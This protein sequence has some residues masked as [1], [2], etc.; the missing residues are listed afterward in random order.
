M[1]KRGSKVS[2]TA[3]QT[4]DLH[5]RAGEVVAVARVSPADSGQA[6]FHWHLGSDGSVRRTSRENGTQRTLR[7]HR[8]ITNVPVGDYTR[9]VI[10]KDGDLLNNTRSNLKIVQV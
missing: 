6:A 2:K 3:R 1:S 8:E 9:R 4:I 7:L 10:H 5:N